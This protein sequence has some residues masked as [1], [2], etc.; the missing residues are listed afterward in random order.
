M[1][2]VCVCVGGCGCVCVCVCVC[3]GAHVCVAQTGSTASLQ[4]HSCFF[5]VCT[6]SEHNI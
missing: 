6:E 5:T 1:H 4:D 2:V 3:V